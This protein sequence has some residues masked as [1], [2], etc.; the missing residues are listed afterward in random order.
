MNARADRF[1]LFDSLRAIAALSVLATHVA[2]VSISPTLRPYGARLEAGLTVF[3]VISGFLLFRPFVRTHVFGERPPRT[4][5]YLWRR[6]LRIGPAYWVALTGIAIVLGIPGFFD[7][8]DVPRYYLFAQTWKESTIGGGLSQAWT[9]CIEVTFYAFLPVWAA[10]LRAVPGA[11]PR[12]RLRND[13]IAVGLLIAASVTYSFAIFAGQPPHKIVIT[14][15]VDSLPGFLD[16]FGMGMAL[17]VLSVWIEWRDRLPRPLE[18]LDRFPGLAWATAA[19]A[20]WAAATQ[21]GLSG[22]LFEPFTPG[23]YLGRHFLYSVV[24][25][26]L[27]TPAVFG[28]PG[29]GLVRRILSNRVLLWFGLVSYGVYLYGPAGHQVLERLGFDPRPPFDS[30]FVWVPA[31]IAVT[32]MLAAGSYYVVERP[33]LSLKRLIPIQRGVRGEAVVEPAPAAPPAQR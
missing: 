2:A 17:A 16:Q 6:A 1:P 28:D 25:L 29:R 8:A 19:V 22:R 4:V 23:Q 21:L 33:V 20:F 11:G 27:V 12:T 3:F 15:A 26:A 9:L 10:I 14:P 24:G 5:A 31:N 32:A 7:S 18:V 13:A 30:F